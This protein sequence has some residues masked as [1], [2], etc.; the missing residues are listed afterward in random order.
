MLQRSRRHEHGRVGKD[1]PHGSEFPAGK[2]ILTAVGK[3]IWPGIFALSTIAFTLAIMAVVGWGR[4]A[5]AEEFVLQAA[6]DPRN[7]TSAIHITG[8]PGPTIDQLRQ[9]DWDATRWAQVIRIEVVDTL[10]AGDLP[11]VLG[12]YRVDKDRLVF[13]PRF[14]FFPGQTYRVV[15]H[16]SQLPGLAAAKPEQWHTTM[17]VPRLNPEQPQG[18]IVAIYPSSDVLPENQLKF[19]I[20]FS[21]PMS[22]GE[23][24]RHIRLLDERGGMVA[25]PF[26]ELPEELWD[27]KRQRFT[28][29]LDPGRIKRG[30]KPREELGPALLEGHKYTLVISHQ[31]RDAF[32]R[33]LKETIRKTFRVTG[34]DTVQP[35]P[36]RWKLNLPAAG[37]RQPLVVQFDEPLDHGLLQRMIWVVDDQQRT[38]DGE[39][40]VLERETVWR[41]IPDTPWKPGTY[42]LRLDTRLEDLAGNSIARPFEVDLFEEV[43][44]SVP[45]EIRDKLFRIGPR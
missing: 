18:S 16:L 38:V 36:D 43:Q 30:L 13:R 1:V 27:P 5:R 15:V 12:Q 3:I 39:R 20:H 32:G 2:N 37:T 9:T 23:A 19:Y 24:Y 33:P 25:Y 35:N 41:F 45:A 17:T 6:L 14:P 28:L 11:P 26:L 42:R 34:P 31:W 21:V 22:R 40:A 7:P 44:S 8:L 29:L 10:Q 4:S